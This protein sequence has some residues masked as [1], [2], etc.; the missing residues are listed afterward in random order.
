[1]PGGTP[2][3]GGRS[4]RPLGGPR[5][6]TS[7]R[8]SGTLAYIASRTGDPAGAERLCRDALASEGLSSG[9]AAILAGQLGALAVHRGDL[10]AALDWLTRAIAGIGHDPQHRASML[11]NRSVAFM[12]AGR[13]EDARRD[14]LDAITDFDATGRPADAAMAEHNLGY[15]LLLEGD[16][17]AAL[18]R[19]A[20]A[21]R[22]MTGVSAVNVAIGDLDRAEVL[23]DAGLVTDAERSLEQVARTFGAEG[24]RQARAEAEFNLARSLLTHDPD[25]GARVAATAARRFRALGSETWATRALSIRARAELTA[26]DAGPAHADATGRAQAPRSV[27]VQ[28]IASDLERLG[29][30]V[31]ALALRLTY[32]RWAAHRGL[33]QVEPAASGPRDAPIQVRLLSDEA[34][35][36][37]AAASG[38]GSDARRYAARGLDRLV[39]WQRSF[40]SLDLQTSIAM[41]GR[42]LMLEGLSAAV[43]SR[44]PAIVFDWSERARHLSQQVV[45]LRPPPDEE[46]AA[47]LSELRRLRAEDVSAAWLAN[48][49]AT[50]LRDR[51]R[52]RQWS[53]IGARGL[54]E[55]ASLD[56]LRR[57]LGADTGFAAYVFSGDR[58][59]CLLL[60]L[61]DTRLVDIGPWSTMRPILAGLR[62]D[63]DMSASV[64]SGPMA[65][66]VAR[67]VTERLADLS[68]VLT[69][70]PLATVGQRRLVLTAPGVL[71]GVPWSMLPANHGRPFTLATSATHWFPRPR[72]AMRGW[73][74][75]RGRTGG[76]SG[77]RGGRRRVEG[78]ARCHGPSRRRRHGRRGTALGSEV[79]VLHV[80][81]HGRHA[82]DNPLFSGLELA[83]GTLSGYEDRPHAQGAYTVVLSACGAWSFLLSAGGG[84]RTAWDPACPGRTRVTCVVRKAA[85][86][87]RRRMSPWDCSARRTPGRAVQD[88]ARRRRCH[89]PTPTASAPLVPS[90]HGSGLSDDRL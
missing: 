68:R 33:E 49:R 62:A 51:V 1:M 63:L 13:L 2:Q 76:A 30:S 80:A 72:T 31:E 77:Q 10:I 53:T 36:A 67:A 9:T 26:D 60:T 38:R 70:G 87:G 85:P 35:A 75:V 40:G 32:D 71:A 39:D 44:R 52:E 34:R 55:P 29:S 90:G 28:R 74:R 3:R 14:L 65:A 81:A 64:R 69:D 25:R 27:A 5:I 73:R 43:R 46:M 18:T 84:Q 66:V 4:P 78:V 48:P 79:G 37:R 82:A 41:H 58:L 88:R 47:E 23:R 56:E 19:M 22:A 54:E 8:D 7:V 6:P 42:G 86:G 59:T 61:D 57:A 89:P 17:V 50:A 45:P 15:V 11:M 83:D 12:Q 16:L 21:R 20:A 24:M